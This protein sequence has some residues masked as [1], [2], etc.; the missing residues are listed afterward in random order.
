MPSTDPASIP[1]IRTSIIRRSHARQD[2]RVAAPVSAA[3]HSVVALVGA[4]DRR[5]VTAVDVGRLLGGERLTA[6]HVVEPGR[7]SR[8]W[9]AGGWT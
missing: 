9:P 3:P 4:V 2:R 1:P 5:A 6:L 8:T 7:T